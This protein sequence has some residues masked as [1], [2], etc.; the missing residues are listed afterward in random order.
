MHMIESLQ[1]GRLGVTFQ[2]PSHSKICRDER[3]C[4]ELVDEPKGVVWW[5]FFFP[6]LHLDVH[7]EHRADLR[8]SLEYY[9]RAMFDD[10]FHK[11]DRVDEQRSP[12]TADPTWSPM[13][14]VEPLNIDGAEALRTVHRMAYEPGSEMIMGHLLLPLRQGLFEARVLCVDNMT[15]VRETLLVNKR[16]KE[17]SPKSEETF[18]Q[19]TATFRQADFDDPRHDDA[20]PEH[21]LSRARAALRWL[22]IESNLRVMERPS[23]FEQGE[24][25]LSHMGCALVPP[26]RFRYDAPNGPSQEGCF[27]RVSFCGTDGVERMYV[28]C[29]DDFAR[30]TATHLPGVAESIAR[31][32]HEDSD[33]KDM[34]VTVETLAPLDQRP[35]ALVIV[36]GMGHL[37]LLRNVMLFFRDEHQLP[38]SLS[39]FGTAAVP[40]EALAAELT[41]AARSFRF[42]RPP[43]QQKPWWRFW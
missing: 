34:R 2:L 38:W 4:A 43:K 21:S 18:K 27:R 22:C 42:I 15:G 9:A 36:E 8:K 14:D 3:E 24:V 23:P 13:I 20:F 35:L 11:R 29:W 30:D 1:T 33:I 41:E 7:E 32:L 40:R 12:R 5:F 37:G 19:M 31:M 10:M 25:E 26:P 28:N 17:R 39:R 16:L 6:D